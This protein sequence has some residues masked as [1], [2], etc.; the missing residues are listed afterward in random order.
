[1]SWRRGWDSNPRND[2]SF[3]AFPVLPVQPLLH[4]SRTHSDQGFDFRISRGRNSSK[5]SPTKKLSKNSRSGS[6]CQVTKPEAVAA[7]SLV[8][9]T[10]NVASGFVSPGSVNFVD[11]SFVD[12][13][14]DQRPQELTLTN[15]NLK[16]S[17]KRVLCGWEQPLCKAS[18][19]DTE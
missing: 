13:T 7:A 15:T 11:C 18:R 9:E 2:F 10:V 8:D 12:L 5:A 16:P 19:V 4:L 1:M 6:G 17:F 3:T 14:P